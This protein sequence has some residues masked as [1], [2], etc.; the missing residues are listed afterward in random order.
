MTGYRAAWAAMPVAQRW[1]MALLGLAVILAN[2]AQPYPSVAPIHHIPTVLLVT[3]APL[4]LRRWPLSNRAV[5]FLLAFWLLH[6]LGG[7]YTY[8]NVPYDDWAIALTGKSISD[9]FGFTR[10]HYDRLVHF[11][12]GVTATPV[13]VETL[14]RHGFSLRASLYV[15]VEFTLAVG[16]AYE[17]FEWWL[18]L[19]MAGTD[20]DLYN[21]Q[22]G[23]IWDAQKDMALAMLG[24]LLMIPIEIRRARR[25]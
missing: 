11:A 20:A 19:V 22:Q 23:D 12:F 17:I 2:I 9:A 7:R 25:A 18:T 5:A 13:I 15:A 8:S 21:G 16:A 3:A 24:A 14:R 4:L 1:M 6:T 10:N